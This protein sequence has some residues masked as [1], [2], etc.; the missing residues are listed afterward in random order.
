MG[1][2][3]SP[4]AV[5]PPGSAPWPSRAASSRRNESTRSGS[6]S[7]PA[8][9]SSSPHSGSPAP[10]VQPRGQ[11]SVISSRS[12]NASINR[13]GRTWAR[14]KER[15]PG[16]SMIQPSPSRQRQQVGRGR[17][18]PAPAGDGVDVPDQAV[19]VGHEGVDQGRLAHA[20]VAHQHAGA[21]AQP[22]A[23]LGQVAPA[24]GDH[25]R[26]AERPVGGEQDLRVGR[27]RPWSGTAA[28]P[29]PASYAATR[30][31]SISRGRGSGSAR[32]VTT[33]SWSALETITRSTGSSSSAVR[34]SVVVRGVDLD[35][36]RQRAVAAADVA[37]HPDP[38]ADHDALAA[39]RPRLHRHHGAV[40]DQQGEP[41]AVHGD[42]HGVDRVVVGG[43]LL[44]AGPG[45]APRT[46]V[47][48]VVGLVVAAAHRV[49]SS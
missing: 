14:P 7:P 20:A 28:G 2:G 47:V 9:A 17:G 5:D 38:V 29:C 23:Q 42:H 41:A 16:V 11:P 37:H 34:R 36:P 32:A 10:W 45:T 15:M 31:R 4:A 25:P 18:V 27:G 19:G 8:S 24:G 26:H 13:S 1:T 3:Y 39:Q 21:A 48:L 30:A 40:L 44:G 22:V 35:D 33:T 46:L 12:G 49:P 6:A 43:A